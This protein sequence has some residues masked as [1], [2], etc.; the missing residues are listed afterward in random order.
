MKVERSA[1]RKPITPDEVP[2]G[3]LCIQITF[4]HRGQRYIMNAMGETRQLLLDKNL[5][6][7]V[8]WHLLAATFS[9]A[10]AVHD[11]ELVDVTPEPK[12]KSES[13]LVTPF[14]RPVGQG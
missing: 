1:T 9:E 8:V 10:A 6:E 2:D 5:R 11:V 12:E 7:R 13:G 3:S 14:G 4:N